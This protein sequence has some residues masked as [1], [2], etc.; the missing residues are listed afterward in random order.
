[1]PQIF[2]EK[3]TFFSL[4][5]SLSL[6]TAPSSI[7]HFDPL[8][9]SA[10]LQL[11]ALQSV[12]LISAD[13]EQVHHHVGQMQNGKGESLHGK[14]L[15]E[16]R[17]L[18]DRIL[19]NE[20]ENDPLIQKMADR[21]EKSKVLLHFAKFV[22]REV[23]QEC[24]RLQLVNWMTG[25]SGDLANEKPVLLIGRRKWRAYLQK[26]SD[27]LGIRLVLYPDFVFLRKM[28]GVV[29]RAVSVLWPSLK[30]LPHR[31]GQ[32]VRT[33]GQGQSGDGSSTPQTSRIAIR[34]WYRNLSF[35]P[36]ERSEFFWFQG[37]P[38]PK[39]EVLLYDVV[40]DHP[41][42]KETVKELRARGIRLYG[43]GPGMT[44]WKPTLKLPIRAI[45]AIL[46]VWAS[47]MRIL[48]RG[49]RVHPY[50]V[51]NL[52]LL[53]IDYAYWYD[54]FRANQV[55]VNVCTLGA[56][57]GQVLAM[58]DLGG[59]TSA[60]QYSSSNLICPTTLLSSGENIQFTFSEP[61]ENL[62]HAIE[63]PVDYLVKTGYIY[64]G[65]IRKL[66]RLNSAVDMREKMKSAGV[67][68]TLCFFDENT[69]NRWDIP[70]SDEDAARD[71]EYLL[72]WLLEEPGLGVIF[73]PK[74]STNLFEPIGS[75]RGLI[76]EACKT[77]RCY[78]LTS[79]MLY[80]NI[81]PAEAAQMADLC[82]G[83]LLGSTAA[84]E[85]RLAGRP[86]IL[87]DTEGF[88]THPF[89]QWGREKVIFDDWP[90]ARSAIEAYRKSP[91]ENTELGNWDPEIRELEPYHDGRAGIRMGQFILWVFDAM[92]K[93]V[94]KSQA[95]DEAAGRF[96][97]QWGS[98]NITRIHL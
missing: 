27:E 36:T 7:R 20:L 71:Y 85:A 96:A 60:Y 54:F 34:Y 9:S 65:V 30:T 15:L 88:R 80:G 18:C 12:G 58:D 66:A 68:F 19:K 24:L 44:A 72:R 16:A 25:R 50:T 47:V 38:F 70:G 39:D 5:K 8:T 28:F 91:H 23:T 87:I 79:T 82:I 4:L 93:K 57:V 2:F 64:D 43:R 40:S 81:Y 76:D 32:R 98:E 42:D 78:F 67:D 51:G 22:E 63:A 6:S 14:V 59:V 94:T 1:M 13:I 56:G 33:R 53:A 45:Q 92:K 11:K 83:K 48:L 97:E 26:R 21:W 84:M 41:L 49:G 62:Y 29:Q 55:K 95:I 89:Q 17:N 46:A 61:F 75:L 35:D 37:L 10:R 73:K 31:L 90:A 86:T 77:G 69:V 3:I 74:N 52:L